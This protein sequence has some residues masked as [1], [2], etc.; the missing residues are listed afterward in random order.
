MLFGE[1]H[2]HVEAFGVVV[3]GAA[4]VAVPDVFDP[5]TL[6]TPGDVGRVAALLSSRRI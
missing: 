5:P 2:D 6:S 4:D 3:A 1:A